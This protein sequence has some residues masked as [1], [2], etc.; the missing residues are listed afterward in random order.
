M[1]LVM[2]SI[3]YLSCLFVCCLCVT[4]VWSEAHAADLPEVKIIKFTSAINHHEYEL[5]ISLPG[6]YSDSSKKYPVVY[7]LDGQWSFPYMV[8]I[9][10]GL[11]Y[12]GLIPE[13]IIVGITW[14]GDYERNRSRD[15]SPTPTN[16]FPGSG[17]APLFL[18]VLKKEIITRINTGFHTEPNNNCLVGG[19]FSGLF[20]LYALLHEPTLF[21]GY[22]VGSPNIGYDND[23]AFSFEKTFAKKNKELQ[24]K[25]FITNGEYEEQT[26]YGDDIKRFVDQMKASSYKGLELER[27]IVEK[28]GHASEGPYGH[29]RGLQFVYG[30]EEVL[31]DTLVLDKYTG[32][33]KIMNDDLTI[34]RIGDHLYVI[35]QK[36]KIKLY[37]K[38][39]DSFYAKG[40]PGSAQF[41]KD[42]N[43]EVI[44]Y[45]ITIGN[46]KLVAGKI[47]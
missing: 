18:Q 13:L 31:L 14:P 3:K 5:H 32:K 39:N 20:T 44:E 26:S 41:K 38:G 29:S 12:D 11:N 1:H 24:V 15:F 10:G 34:T 43:G 37:A 23:L 19:S 7:V 46:D 33:Y 35:D 4:A 16:E 30:Q 47:N 42:N 22:V 21:K 28:M 25:L 27:L 45:V 40:F 6:G 36:S 17:G 2:T 9:N 8:G